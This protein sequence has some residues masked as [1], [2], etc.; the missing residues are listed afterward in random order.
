MIKLRTILERLSRDRVIRRTLQTRHGQARLFVSPD[1]ELKY[2]KPDAFHGD[3]IEIVDQF[4][5]PD[6]C[7]W[8]VGANVGVF[9]FAATRATS[10]SVILIE[11]DAWLC[12]LLRRTAILPEYA[13]HDVRVVTVA[14]ADQVGVSEFL[15]ASR[16]RA[17]NALALAGGRSQMG[18]V[19]ERIHVPT[20]TL[21]TLA[22]SFPRPNFIKID[23]EG[24]EV[25]VITGARAI[26]T[27]ARPVIYAEVGKESFSQFLNEINKYQ[28]ISFSP[29]G[30]VTQAPNLL[31]YFFVHRD[32]STARM[33][34]EQMKIARMT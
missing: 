26:L 30:E 4:L 17:S 32:D 12:T 20:L 2:L 29:A 16:G 5:R 10:N 7:V 15:I 6:D 1:A 22:E 33:R 9:G 23:V 21:D 28:Y 19:R 11:A 3:L 8:D 13:K 25:Q 27:E 31:N 34:L 24:A 18:G 14:A